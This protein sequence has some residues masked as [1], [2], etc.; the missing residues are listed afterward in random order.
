[1]NETYTKVS[2]TEAE[3]SRTEVKKERLDII[4]LRALRQSK[5]DEIATIRAEADAQIASRQSEID[6][7]TAIIQELK[8][9]G[10]A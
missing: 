3:V 4:Q 1:M 2:D 7:I 9:V 8:N 5:K 10:I 6:Q